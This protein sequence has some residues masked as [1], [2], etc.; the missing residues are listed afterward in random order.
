M[1]PIATDVTH[2]ILCVFLTVCVLGYATTA[3][4]TET[5]FGA[6]LMS[7]QETMY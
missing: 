1:W 2:N 4:P 3:E 5:P 6:W 7:F